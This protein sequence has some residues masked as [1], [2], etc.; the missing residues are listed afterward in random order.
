MVAGGFG[1]LGAAGDEGVLAQRQDRL[2]ALGKA[3]GELLLVEGER[4]AHEPGQDRHEIGLGAGAGHLLELDQQRLRQPW[5]LLGEEQ[6]G[7]G[8]E[9][10]GAELLARWSRVPLRSARP[11]QERA[12]ARRARR[13]GAAVQSEAP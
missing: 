8:R 7:A 9:R 4:R 12:H 3:S 11:G 13:A 10:Q 2:D 5:L 6:P 1:E